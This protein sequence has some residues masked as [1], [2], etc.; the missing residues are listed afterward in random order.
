MSNTP[1]IEVQHITKRFKGL[2]AVKDVSFSIREGAITGMIGPNGAGKSTTFNMIC[3]YYPPTEGKI[4]FRGQDITDKKA[5]EYT[6]MKIARTFQIM[7]P[8]KNLSVLE[9]VVASC[10]FGH[11]AARSE[12]EARERAME[13]LEFTGLFDKRHIL[14][15]DMGTPDQKR[16]EMA[17]ALATKP[18]LLFL[19][20]NM[21]GLNPAETEAA[22]ELIR[23][24]NRSGVTIF[25]IEHIMQAVVSLCEE[26]IVLH[27]GEKIAEGTPE[28]VMNDPYVMEV[29]L[30]TKGGAAHA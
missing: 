6:K 15:K 20:E 19:D 28:Q 8:L 27:H 22:I 18:E 17:R 24:I 5:H 3:G 29:Y 25:L 9:N 14:S 16:L 13:I 11:A 30:G 1:I 26:V 10:Y 12:R 7:K 23:Q 21:A 4:F 2:T